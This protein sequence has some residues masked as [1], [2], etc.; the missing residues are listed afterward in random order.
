MGGMSIKH[1][2]YKH[3][4]MS[5]IP[6]THGIKIRHD[7]PCSNP[8]TGEVDCQTPGAYWLASQLNACQLLGSWHLPNKDL[9]ILLTPH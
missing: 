2:P 1:M 8:S 4:D 7:D 9:N 6:S 5:L 3:E